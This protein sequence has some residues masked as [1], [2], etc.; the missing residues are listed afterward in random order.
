M[1]L[2]LE[3]LVHS[4]FFLSFYCTNIYFDDTPRCVYFFFFINIINV[5][6]VIYRFQWDMWLSHH[7]GTNTLEERG[8]RRGK[9]TTGAGEGDEGR[10]SK[11]GVVTRF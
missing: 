3:S 9:V 4:F 1:R 5:L 7:A 11:T 2:R 6:T 8:T 10:G